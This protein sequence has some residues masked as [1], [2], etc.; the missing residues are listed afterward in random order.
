MKL[1]AALLFVFG[2]LPAQHGLLKQRYLSELQRIV[3]G[4]DAVVGYS[5]KDLRTGE[6]FVWND[7]EIFP[8]ASSIKLIILAEVYRQAAAG[9]FALT[10]V[11]P[12]SPSAQVGG[13]GVLSM[14]TPGTVSLSI[15]DYGVLMINISDNSATNMLIGLTG[16]QNINSFAASLG[17]STLT[18]QR[19]MMDLQAA[20]EDRENIGTPADFTTLL[21]KLYREELVSKE[22]SRD[23]LSILSLEKSGP[24]NSG[25]PEGIRIAG[26]S[27]EIDG[28][29]CDVAIV[30]LRNNP[31]IISVMTKLLPDA[32]E[33]N[34]II[35]EISRATYNF[36]ERKTNSNKYGRR[37]P[38]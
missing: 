6:S 25:V 32:A 38:Q 7:K 15:R 26:K 22:A 20:K 1:I 18:L 24:I 5:I 29:R 33:G 2:I 23:M 10:D 34:R 11:R 3:S 37:I 17:C 14:L 28:T 35:T 4:A 8:T 21:E 30:Y 12:L 9:K 31:Y 13:S 27:G 16:M 19:V 36:L